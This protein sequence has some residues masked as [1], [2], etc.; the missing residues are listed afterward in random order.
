MQR[1]RIALDASTTC[2]LVCM[3]LLVFLT[4]CAR[5]AYRQ[6]ADADVAAILNE[7]TA[8][9]TCPNPNDAGI[10]PDPRSRLFDAS[11]E[12]CPRLPDPRPAINAY[13]LPPLAS[14]DPVAAILDSAKDDDATSM[15]DLTN[16]TTS[17]G[18]GQS[19]PPGGE[20]D[21][22]ANADANNADA[23]ND[24]EPENANGI[25][26][27]AVPEDAW[28]DLPAT[29]LDRMLEFESI[30]NEYQRSFPDQPSR[31][32]SNVPRL[33]LENLLELTLL[34][35]RAYQR[36]KETLYIAALRLTQ[37]R[38]LYEL[39]P[40]PFGN[41]TATDYRHTRVAGVTTNTLAI[42]TTAGA[43]RSL[44]SG[45]Q[46]LTTFAN[47]VVLTFNGPQGFS[48]SI[49]SQLLFDLQQSLLQN[50][51]QFEALTQSE[52]DVIYAARDFCRFRRSQFRDIA[53]RY[54]NLLLNYRSIEIN[55]QDY[56]SNLRAYLQ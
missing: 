35:S 32:S 20:K 41:G 9:L 24:E 45:A 12:D 29:C 23:N 8:C 19:D 13:S 26:I 40:V 3:T 34:N 28:G 53:T 37:Q 49:S 55:T 6:R 52:R 31:R 4:G 17:D 33:S 5:S 56:F 43:R 46:F 18:S 48:K 11:P 15:S 22:E 36:Q 27:V 38:Y 39:R 21:D 2:V 50:D 51:V 54:Y 16:D 25:R 42:P 47:D 30:R 14:G 10:T 7:K 44:V 1:N